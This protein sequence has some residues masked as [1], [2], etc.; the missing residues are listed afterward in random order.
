MREQ[1]KI[2][3]CGHI[4]HGKSTLIGRLLM[5]TGSLPADKIKDLKRIAKDFDEE[6]QLAYLTDQLKEERERNITIETTQTFL[7]TKKRHYC[8]IDTPGHLEFIKNMLSGASQADSAL[9]VVDIN[10]GIQ[11]QTRRHA[12]L[13][14]FLS[15]EN[16][17][18]LVN[19]MDSAGYSQKKFTGI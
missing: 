6:A 10:E 9:L 17:I 12:Y 11:E 7:Q 13:L 3:V 18:V 16:I 4:D 2:A 5:D 19:K 1:I 8:L 15:L 14:Y